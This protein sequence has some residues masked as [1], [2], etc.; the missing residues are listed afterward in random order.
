VKRDLPPLV[1]APTRSHALPR[2]PR[3]ADAGWATARGVLCVRLDNLGD[4]VMTTPALHALRAALPGRTLTLLTSPGAAIAAPHLADVD[5]VIAHTASWVAADADLDADRAL[6][7]RLAAGAFDAA[8]IFTVYSQSPLPAALMCRL[9]GIPLVLAHCR[10]NPGALLSD[11]LPEPEPDIA[12]RHETQRQLDLVAHVGARLGTPTD[13][14]DVGNPATRL[15]FALRPADRA[16]AGA[17]LAEIGLANVA[18]D[19]TLAA[20]AADDA[21]TTRFLL[22]HP[23]ATAESRRY[24]PAQF[25]AALDAIARASG[26]P[27]LIGGSGGEHALAEAVATGMRT[28]AYN[29][30]GRLSLGGAAALIER[31]A[32]LVSNNS[33]PVHLAAALGTPVVDLYALT[34]PQHTPWQVRYRLLFRDQPCRHCYRS[35]CPAGHHACLDAITPADVAAAALDLLA[36]RE[37]TT[38]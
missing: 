36:E 34:N 32:L 31:A 11:W 9:A 10:E 3:P 4:V 15:R 29:V 20:R 26:L 5:A 35:V 23:G 14:A 21:P 18:C 7:A 17:L 6:P 19:V 2:A 25:A 27:V 12:L 22:A 8:V 38:C 24:P 33:A 1:P 28:C 13:A 30:A 37:P 16:E